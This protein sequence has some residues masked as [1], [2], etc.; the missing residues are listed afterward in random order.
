[1]GDA[2]GLRTA[3]HIAFESFG[4]RI[5]VTADTPEVLERIPALLP[6]G[7]TP[8]SPDDVDESFGILADVGGTYRFT[9]EDSPVTKGDLGLAMMLLENQVRISVGLHAPGMIFIHAGVVGHRGKAIVIPG[10]SFAGKTTLVLALVRAGATYYSDEFAVLDQAG[11][12]HPYAKPLSIRDH[13]QVQSDHEVERFGGAAGDEP[14]DIGV[15][16][17]TEYRA[18]AEWDPQP[19]SPGQGALKLLANTLAARARSAEALPA[20]RRAIAG[21][22][23]LDGPRGEAERVVDRLIKAVPA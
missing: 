18:N 16:A 7:S 3:Q 17:F 12:V 4:A 19:I 20:I 9:R 11:R 15:V 13:D 14:V 23:L 6:P 5:R 1:V 8:C 21:A 10:L 22:V 2:T